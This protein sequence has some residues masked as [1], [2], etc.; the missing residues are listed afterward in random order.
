[1]TTY[2][3]KD[4]GTHTQYESGMRRDSQDGKPRFDLIRTRLQPYEEQMITRYARLL[5]RGAEKYDDRNWEEGFGEEELERAKGSLLRHTEQ[6]IAGETDEDHAA[7]VWFN[8][9]AIEYFRWRQGQPMP[10][11]VEEAGAAR[12]AERA[13]EIHQ[14]VLQEAAKMR[15][16]ERIHAAA[17]ELGAEPAQTTTPGSPSPNSSTTLDEALAREWGRF[18]PPMV[19]EDPVIDVNDD[20][21]PFR[22][23]DLIRN[24]ESGAVGLFQ[25]ANPSW[26]APA[27]TPFTAM[28]ERLGEQIA[29]NVRERYKD[30]SARMLDL[31][32]TPKYA[33]QPE[34][35]MINLTANGDGSLTNDLTGET[36]VPGVEQPELPFDDE[37]DQN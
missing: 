15:R 33:I 31:H 22:K 17:Q 10:Q 24:K 32:A 2:E 12:R 14:A 7:A 26:S 28:Q 29:A 13:S 11:D 1:M 9:Q 8:S 35:S 4:S 36:V 21:T 20:G 18:D 23:G 25:F 3:T 30:F 34:P 16:R 19:N 5:A 27:F 6:L 37:I